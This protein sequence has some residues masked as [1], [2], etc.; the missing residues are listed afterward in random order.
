VAALATG[1]AGS[2]E[3][4]RAVQGVKS[5]PLPITPA[6]RKGLRRSTKSG[7]TRSANLR[8]WRASRKPATAMPRRGRAS[9]P[10]QAA[11][12]TCRR[13]CYVRYAAKLKNTV[14]AG[15]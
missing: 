3:T 14:P 6:R 15:V 2:N 11:A 1:T 7:S 12:I 5:A 13:F 10:S 8:P 4:S 9:L